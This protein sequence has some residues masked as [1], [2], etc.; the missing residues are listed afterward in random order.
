M[1]Y[2]K[3]GRTGL[4][5]S[6]LCLG[7]M[8]YGVP[9]RG[10]HPWSLDNDAARP[11]I[12]QALDLGINFFD[13]A[14]VYSDG[15]SEEIVGRAL[16][17][18]ASRDEI[19]LATKVH[20]RMRP[21]PNGAGLSRKAIMAEIDASLRRLGTD[22]VDLY[23]IHRWDDTTPI[24]ETM[25]ALHDVVKAGKARYIGASTM[26]AWQFSKA[27]HVSE[28]HGWTRF[29][30][31]QN[32]VNLLYRE[33]EREM[34]PLCESE[35]IGVI[36]WSP[37]ARGRL[38]RDWNSSSARSETDEFGRTLYAATEEADRQIVERVS[39]IATKRGVPRAQV[40]LA[41]VLQKKP[42]T[43]PIVGATKLH[44]LSDAVA[45]VSLKLTTDEIQLLEERY[46]P[47]AVTG[48]K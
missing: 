22:Y 17:D 20:G 48:F 11:F 45:A 38:T 1:E 29:V 7:C 28:R 43:A 34:L 16:K 18:F 47:H 9:D 24:E 39:E 42:V 10:P 13:T 15:T 5:V 23:Q 26:Y 4:D 12:K 21:G 36:P 31:M 35:G 46:V 44:H 41:W 32:Y 30:T 25:E 3:L 8:S 2:V 19:V 33:E 40:A 27:L 37:L 14:N 6:R